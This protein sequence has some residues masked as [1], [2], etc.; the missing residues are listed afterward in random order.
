MYIN[1]L[2]AN[3]K[4]VLTAFIIVYIILI[5]PIFLTIKIRVNKGNNRLFYT[6]VIFGFI[7]LLN[8]YLEL[9]KEGIAIHL[10]RY[11]AIIIP[12]KNIFEMRN[13]IKP[14]KDYHIIKFNIELALGLN[15]S[16]I[17][18][19]SISFL[20]NY[21]LQYV[22]WFL[23]NKKPYVKIDTNISLYEN[24]NIA[25][26]HVKA[27]VVFNLMM[28]IISL[29]KIGVEKVFYAIKNRK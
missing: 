3:I 24:D 12:L 29:I 16:L 6:I 23:Y 11:K 7:K 22:E 4:V 20:L 10:T 15:N 28:V 26:L 21:I 5:F 25:D 27:T 19:V 9:I 13:K 18:P 14:L 2:N 1:N 17:L 8:G